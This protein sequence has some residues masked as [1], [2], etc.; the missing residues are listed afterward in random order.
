MGSDRTLCNR[1]VLPLS[2]YRRGKPLPP[3][4]LLLLLA[5][6]LSAVVLPG[7]G[8][9]KASRLLLLG[10]DLFKRKLAGFKRKSFRTWF[11]KRSSTCIFIRRKYVRT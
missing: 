3:V 10:L 6:P 9:E 8:S 2:Q 11:F 1:V 7:V 4:L 5:P